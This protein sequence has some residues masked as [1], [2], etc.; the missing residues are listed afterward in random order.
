MP[1][2]KEGRKKEMENATRDYT[3]NMHKRMH[4]VAFKKRAPKAVRIVKKFAIKEMHTQVSR[5][6]CLIFSLTRSFTGHP[7]GHS[8]EQIPV[9]EGH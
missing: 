9:E 5:S 7:S 2:T 6:S 1:R 3:L 8:A 4:G